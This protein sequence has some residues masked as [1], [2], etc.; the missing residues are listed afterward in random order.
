VTADIP[1]IL[2]PGLMCTEAVWGPVIEQWEGSVAAQPLTHAPLTTVEAQA[3]A[4]LRR[5]PA[6]FALAGHSFGGYVAL[7]MMRLAPERVSHLIL[8]ASSGRADGDEQRIGRDQL[9]RAAQ[10]GKYASIVPR[11]ASALLAPN[12]QQDAALIGRL[13]ELA[14][15]SGVEAFIAHLTAIKQRPDCYDLLPR[16]AVPTLIAAGEQDRVTSP[17]EQQAMAG[18]IP[19]ATLRLF[20]NCGHMTPLEQPA[21][22]AAAI[23]AHLEA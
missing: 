13:S 4:I 1:L 16:I 3:E 10:A 6:R 9:I 15:A 17:P 19:G 18:A 8:V 14:A 7:A 11:M 12:H 5:A 21:K 23:R 20:D 22:L 2:L